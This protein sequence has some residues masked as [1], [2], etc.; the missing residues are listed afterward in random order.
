MKKGERMSIRKRWHKTKPQSFFSPAPNIFQSPSPFPQAFLHRGYELVSCYT[1][2][3]NTISII[4]AAMWK[5]C[6][7]LSCYSLVS[8][9]SRIASRHDY[10]QS[11]SLCQL[12]WKL[13]HNQISP[14]SCSSH[15]S[16]CT[17]HSKS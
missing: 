5:H 3:G 12:H 1:L 10:I 13:W 15:S 4:T 11:L 7:L 14:C 9:S 6:L 2:I 16:I 8:G 17:R